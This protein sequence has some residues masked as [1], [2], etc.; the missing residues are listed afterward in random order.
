[1]SV[2]GKVYL[3]GQEFLNEEYGYTNNMRSSLLYGYV[4][5]SLLGVSCGQR[6][7]DPYAGA[8][9]LYTPEYAKGFLLKEVGNNRILQSE[10]FTY[11]LYPRSDSLQNRG[12]LN[13]IPYPIT[14]A[15]CLS[16][17]HVAYLETIGKSKVITGVSGAQ[18]LSNA[19]IREAVVQGNVLDVGYEGTLNYEKVLSLHPDVVFAYAIPGAS[20]AYLKPLIQM[21]VPVIYLSDFL[22]VH[23]LGKAEYMVAFSALF[24]F[25][26]FEDA[27]STFRTICTEYFHLTT[28]VTD[29]AF[30]PK[31]L[32]N[33]PFKDVWYFPGG[34]N[35]LSTLISDAGGV[36]LGSKEG[37]IESQPV[38]LEQ[39][40]LYA[41]EADI[42]LHP[43]ACRT[44]H[45]LAESELRFA[46]IPAFKS[47]SV[48]NNTLRSTVGGGSDFW[49]RGV[50][51]PH[52]ILADLIKIFHPQLLPEHEFV[53]YERL[54]NK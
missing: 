11:I 27:V 38:S 3:C 42:W 16:T 33:A 20:D 22:E 45:D 12:K 54:A 5:L 46:Q 7:S 48:Y 43:N 47:Q 32:M 14:H 31:I 29:I 10:S 26:V 44:L 1:M 25:P 2:K 8:A 21:G 39:A 4:F 17:T 6:Q 40:Y 41:L 23:P 51:E 9:L 15:V 13:H 30:T 19:A 37:V 24:D 53:Y 36:V 49:E 28:Y 18:Y 35:Y 52:I 34:K 50:T